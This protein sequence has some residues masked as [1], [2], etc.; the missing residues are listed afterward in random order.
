[1][2]VGLRGAGNPMEAARRAPLYRWMIFMSRATG[3]AAVQVV[4]ELSHRIGDLDVPANTVISGDPF[5]SPAGDTSKLGA[6]SN[7]HPTEQAVPFSRLAH[8]HP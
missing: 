4:V 8:F 1:M 2:T 6:V 5:P 3:P 7:R